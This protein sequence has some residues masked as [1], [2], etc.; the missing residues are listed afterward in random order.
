MLIEI[1]PNKLKVGGFC[2]NGEALTVE[3][4]SA[5][6]FKVYTTEQYKLGKRVERSYFDLMPQYFENEK[7][8]IVHAVHIIK[9]KLAALGLT[10]S[11]YSIH[12]DY[13]DF[14]EGR[15][16]KLAISADEVA[17]NFAAFSDKFKADGTP[18]QKRAGY[19]VTNLTAFDPGYEEILT[20]NQN[21]IIEYATE[22]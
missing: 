18:Y 7:N 15:P 10:E 2:L 22:S 11:D 20:A 19:F 3:I 21:V 16:I 9:A 1:K 4:D 12:C 17:E 6:S 13:V 8:N 14:P 5:T